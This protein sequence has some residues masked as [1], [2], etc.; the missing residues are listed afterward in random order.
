MANIPFPELQA[1][2]SEAAFLTAPEKEITFKAMFG[3][4]GVYV[5]GIILATLSNV[6]IGLKLSPS[7][8]DELLAQAGAKRLQYDESMPPSKSYI[9]PPGSMQ[10]NAIELAKWVAYSIEFVISLPPPKNKKR[11]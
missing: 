8:Q 3:G 4:A 5:D 9:Q 1:V 6:G 2:I 10:S 11:K 7:H